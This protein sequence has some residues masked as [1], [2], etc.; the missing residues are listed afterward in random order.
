MFMNW[1]D[2]SSWDGTNFKYY[3]SNIITA[4]ESYAHCVT[5]VGWDDN[6]TFTG[7]P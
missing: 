5:I 1:N 4:D 3:D 6:Y 2:P 7:A